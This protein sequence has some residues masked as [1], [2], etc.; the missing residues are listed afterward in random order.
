MPK[1]TTQQNKND[2][3]A[4]SKRGPLSSK[5]FNSLCATLRYY[6]QCVRDL[7]TVYRKETGKDM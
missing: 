3:I 1:K 7:Q 5:Q 2:L 4:A 6:K